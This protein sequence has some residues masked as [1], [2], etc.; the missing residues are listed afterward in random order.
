M[1]LE[2]NTFVGFLFPLTVMLWVIT[3]FTQNTQEILISS[4]MKSLYIH[5]TVKLSSYPN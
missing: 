2:Q 3:F 1:K 5:L 4:C